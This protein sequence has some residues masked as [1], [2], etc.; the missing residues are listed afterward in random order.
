MS[1]M[2]CAHLKDSYGDRQCCLLG[3]GRCPRTSFLSYPQCQTLCV[4]GRKGSGSK[5]LCP[6]PR[7]SPRPSGHVGAM[8]CVGGEGGTVGVSGSHGSSCHTTACRPHGPRPGYTLT[9]TPAEAGQQPRQ[10]QRREYSR[11]SEVIWGT[12]FKE[13]HA[14]ALKWNF[15]GLCATAAQ[16][17]VWAELDCVCRAPL[18]PVASPPRAG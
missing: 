15:Y 18:F 7:A 11:C 16:R 12:S 1:P 10:R 13:A 3:S 6:A 4:P 17:F 8:L 5:D 14:R 9:G 2:P